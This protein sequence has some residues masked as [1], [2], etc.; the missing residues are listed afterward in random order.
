[1]LDGEEMMALDKLGTA[2]QLAC[3]RGAV[4]AAG[5]ISLPSTD[6]LRLSRSAQR[7]CSH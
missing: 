1:M 4:H 7:I 2:Q 3:I 6:S 5:M